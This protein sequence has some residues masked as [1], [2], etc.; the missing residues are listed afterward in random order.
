MVTT[1]TFPGLVS[2]DPIQGLIDYVADIKPYHTKVFETLVEYVYTDFVNVS[3]VDLAEWNIPIS[4]T[5]ALD[6]T[7][8][9]NSTGVVP[10]VI[11]EMFDFFITAPA[12]TLVP[13]A[14]SDVPN[15]ILYFS[16]DVTLDFSIGDLVVV[17]NNPANKF[18]VLTVGY[19]TGLNQTTVTLN[20]VVA[21]TAATIYHTDTT[22][23]FALP[24]QSAVV[25]PISVT[26]PVTGTTF[27]NISTFTVE[28]N[29]TRSLQ[30][31]SIIQAVAALDQNTPPA[32]YRVA[33]VQFIA[34]FNPDGSRNPNDT[35]L[36]TSVIGVELDAVFT[37]PVL[38]TGFLIPYNITGYDGRYDGPY[39]RMAGYQI[40]SG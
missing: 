23:N 35:T 25:G 10:S 2:I 27:N 24:I 3:I 34:G 20:T 39:D 8:N 7:I 17:D 30:P 5:D 26:E 6:P 29:A 15:G 38:S 14:S 4:D 12:P 13:I 16:T 31:G 11:T 9:E 40:V 32:V 22:Y 1:T 18:Q 28:G 36:D 37:D 21:G 33:F 19:D